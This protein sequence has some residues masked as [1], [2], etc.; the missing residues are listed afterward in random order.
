MPG[1]RKGAGKPAMN[2]A[3]IVVT[4]N[5]P[6]VVSGG[7]PLAEQSI[8]I[9]EEGDSHGWRE[10]RQFPL[11]QTYALCRCGH[12]LNPPFC[13]GSHLRSDFDGRE[14][15][16]REP[17]QQQADLL[18]GPGL[19]LA[20]APAFCARARFCHRAGGTWNLTEQSHDPEARRIAIEEAQDCPSGR[21]VA[22]KKDGD[23]LEPE[24]EPSIGVTYDPQLG[25][26]GPLWVRGG[27]QIVAAD[28]APYERRNRV[29]LCRCGKSH[30]KPFRDGSHQG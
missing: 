8:R 1:E 6:Y 15:A 10:G 30:N 17:F 12:S 20:D 16:A 22:M 9:D 18:E 21:L 2:Q 14:T 24:L 13:D 19:D 29:T 28:G 3:K 25:E 5:G 4:N 7:V 26:R 23:A 11:R 27:V